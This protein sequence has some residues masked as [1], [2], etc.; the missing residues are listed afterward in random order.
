V[1]RLSN[2]GIRRYIKV[3][4]QANPYLKE[5]AVIS[6]SVEMT[7][8]PKYGHMVR[9][10]QPGRPT[11]WTFEMLEPYDGKLSR[12]VL[13]GEWGGNTPDLPDFIGLTRGKL[14]LI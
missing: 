11:R 9:C 8:T 7:K 2:I 4:A 1:I 10:H 6:I 3:R 14:L 13:R 12:T 5:L